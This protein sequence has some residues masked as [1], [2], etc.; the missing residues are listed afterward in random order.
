MLEKSD[1]FYSNTGH[2]RMVAKGV[3]FV[4]QQVMNPTTIY[5]DAGLIPVLAL[6]VKDPMLP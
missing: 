5:E 2:L 3:P 4:T 1:T 6:W